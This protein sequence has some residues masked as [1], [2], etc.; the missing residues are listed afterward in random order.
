MSWTCRTWALWRVSSWA[1]VASHARL[2]ATAPPQVEAIIGG[3]GGRVAASQTSHWER[4]DWL[5]GPHERAAR[6]GVQDKRAPQPCRVSCRKKC[7]SGSS[8]RWMEGSEGAGD[9]RLQP[10]AGPLLWEHAEPNEFD[11]LL[12]SINH[13]MQN[14]SPFWIKAFITLCLFTHSHKIDWLAAAGRA[15]S[16]TASPPPHSSSS[17]IY[18]FICFSSLSFSGQTSEAVDEGRRLWRW[19][20]DAQIRQGLR[21]PQ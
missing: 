14:I 3:G 1:A 16:R 4:R 7:S 13:A 9:G 19:L 12:S 2:Y 20:G 6:S 5:W 11:S 21:W 18:I 15:I 8:G 17:S 10:P